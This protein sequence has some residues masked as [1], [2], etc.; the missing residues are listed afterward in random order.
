VTGV[1]GFAG[2]HLARRL[3]AEGWSVAGTVRT[4][5]AGIA[6][7]E[8]HRLEIDDRDA[9]RA[10]VEAFAPEVV[11]HLAAIVD[12]VHTRD[13]LHLHRTNTM[14]TVAVLEALRD[15]GSPARVLYASSAFAYGRTAPEMQPVPESAPLEPLTPYGASKAAGEAIVLQWARET[16]RE[17]VVTRAFQHTGPGHVGAYAMADWA[18]QIARGASVIRCGNIDVARDYLDVRDVASAYHAVME[19]GHAGAVYNVGSGEPRTMRSLLEGLIEAFGG[20]AAI[21]V[22]PARLR[23]IDQPTFYADASRLAAHTGWRPEYRMEDTLRDLAAFWREREGAGV[24][25]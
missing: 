13:V 18:A 12:T 6:G 1:S 23:A 2:R 3:T 21:E 4:R 22:D 9:L 19:R 14:G 11:Y 17:V 10:V 16:G 8:E 5:P 7:V 15:A 25:A 24:L 20:G